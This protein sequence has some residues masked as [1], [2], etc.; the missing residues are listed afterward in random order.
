MWNV[1]VQTELKTNTPFKKN[2][3]KCLGGVVG[4]VGRGLLTWESVEHGGSRAI[5][6]RGGT[7]A[8]GILKKLNL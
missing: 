6:M 1:P 4:L 2:E 3:R 7:R 8:I 5:G